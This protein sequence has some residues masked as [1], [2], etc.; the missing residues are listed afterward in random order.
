MIS[1]Y[2]NVVNT[3]YVIVLQNIPWMHSDCI[4]SSSSSFVNI[5][6][7]L[8]LHY[9]SITLHAEDVFYSQETA[10]YLYYCST[11]FTMKNLP[12]SD[13]EKLIKHRDP[14]VSYVKPKKS[15]R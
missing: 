4:S 14:S 7:Y 10:G 11:D 15:V 2:V 1:T 12:K 13:I 8:V 5:V 6:L 3:I 9:I